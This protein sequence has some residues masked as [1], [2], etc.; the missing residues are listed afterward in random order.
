[1]N[2]ERRHSTSLLDNEF[3]DVRGTI[4]A[5]VKGPPVSQF[6]HRHG[7]IDGMA[8]VLVTDAVLPGRLVN[9]HTAIA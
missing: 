9:L 2:H 3:E 1:M 4:G 6:G 7:V 5:E 8:D